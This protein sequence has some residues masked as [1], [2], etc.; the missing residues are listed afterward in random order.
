[1][2]RLSVSCLSFL[3]VVQVTLAQECEARHRGSVLC[4]YAPEDYPSTGISPYHILVSYRLNDYLA[5]WFNPA[6]GQ[7]TAFWSLWENAALD[8]IE[9][10]SIPETVGNAL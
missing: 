5:D 7:A 3:L 1:M 10:D 8:Y 2:H 4:P 9:L 6:D